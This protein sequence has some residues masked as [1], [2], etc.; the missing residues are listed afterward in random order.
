MKNI[1]NYQSIYL[2]LSILFVASLSFQTNLQI[3]S[4]LT[5]LLVV[6]R[7]IFWKIPFE[8]SYPIKLLLIASVGYY[9]LYILGFFQSQNQVEALALAERYLSFLF[10]PIIIFTSPA[11]TTYQMQRIFAFFVGSCCVSLLFSLGYA[12][13]HLFTYHTLNYFFYHRLSNTIGL[14]GTYFAIYICFSV[15]ISIYY[16]YKTKNKWW[17]ISLFITTI[18][19][20]LLSSRTQQ[21]AALFAILFIGA[22][23]SYSNKNWK[24]FIVSC[25]ICTIVAILF[26][27]NPGAKD[28]NQ[29]D[30]V[31]DNAYI[32]SSAY[33]RENRWNAVWE[34]IEKN[35]WIGTGSGDVQQEMDL[36]CIK[37]K[38]AQKHIQ[39]HNSHNQFLQTWAGTGIVG[40]FLLL[41]ILY[42]S[43]KIAILS[44]SELHIIFL[45]IFVISCL[46]EVVLEAQKGVIWFSFFNSLFVHYNS[47][48]NTT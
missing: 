4:I 35:K 48:Y 36:I 29:S 22:K 10:F 40:L 21:L 38:T 16:W 31:S 28:R 7:L 34:I 1:Q 6:N 8:I 15:F 46:T 26:W 45:C 37:N 32:T 47:K 23:Y 17:I 2:L 9:G 30:T 11:F 12:T 3:S 39:G 20:Y 25:S 33:F 19:L 27:F 43:Y 41:F 44:N 42:Q 13:Y 18:G 14:H 5:I 24:I